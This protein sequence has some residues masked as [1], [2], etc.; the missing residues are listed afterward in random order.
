MKSFWY[1]YFAC[2]C[3]VLHFWGFAC[4]IEIEC[5]VCRP[6]GWPGWMVELL[7]QCFL[8]GWLV[9]GL[10]FT[11]VM[12]LLNFVDFFDPKTKST[13]F[14]CWI[15]FCSSMKNSR[16]FFWVDLFI[17]FVN[18]FS[19]GEVEKNPE[20]KELRKHLGIMHYILRTNPDLK[21]SKKLLVIYLRVKDL[22]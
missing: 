13:K 11:V 1:L 6:I 17:F 9:P 22:L 7:E 15:F 14:S 12:F 20:Y 16:Q 3:Q 19:V 5:L 21:I 10:N 4:E 18:F 2:D 8:S